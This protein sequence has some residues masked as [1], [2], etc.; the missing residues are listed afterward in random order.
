MA[1]NI[2]VKA[3]LNKFPEPSFIQAR[4]RPNFPRLL[5]HEP[6]IIL[7]V[8]WSLLIGPMLVQV[9]I[10]VHKGTRVICMSPL[11][12]EERQEIVSRAERRWQHKLE[13]ITLEH[14]QGMLGSP[15]VW[16]RLPM[17]LEE[18]SRIFI[19]ADSAASD[20]RHADACTVAA[21][22]QA[23]HIL[24]ERGV[25]K[26]IPIV[27]EI[28]DPRTEKLCKI[29]NISSFVDSSG[30]PVQVLAA[31]C[32][33]PR[34]REVLR[35]VVGDD[36][37]VGYSIRSLSDYLPDGAQLPESLNF[38]Q[39]HQIVAQTDDVVIGWSWEDD[40]SHANLD[41]ATAMSAYEGRGSECLKWELNPADK[42]AM[43]Q[44]S[45]SDRICVLGPH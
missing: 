20:K 41:F 1:H 37:A 36:E 26:Q 18:A 6:E 12:V 5:G 33:Q 38:V 24:S 14:V 4:T 29:C 21:V 27:P 44:W 43:R 3:S 19:L 22:M 13:N 17:R 7:V 35:R 9:D 39:I 16:D 11:P 25:E 23:R 10:E 45:S 32:F 15:T 31:V 42:A 28:Q 30:M 2:D 34:L 8:G 40:Y